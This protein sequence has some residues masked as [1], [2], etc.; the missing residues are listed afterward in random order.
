M[1][2]FMVKSTSNIDMTFIFQIHQVHS[3]E[4]YI[5]EFYGI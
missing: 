2:Y 1:E 4:G 3:L 5:R